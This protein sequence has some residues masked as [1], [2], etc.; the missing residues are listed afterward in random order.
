MSRNA[1]SGFTLI[2]LLVAMS[3]MALGLSVVTTTLM[4]RGSNFE[5]RKIAREIVTLA[6]ET[7]YRANHEGRPGT[8]IFDSTERTLSN[9]A[10]RLLNLPEPFQVEMESAASAGS[11]R[12]A[13]YPGGI[14]SGGQVRLTSSQIEIVVK[15]DWLTSHIDMV[16]VSP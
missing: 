4:R 10:G 14:S 7:R 12:I 2:E 9:E 13:F 8:L 15:V 11:G 16:E 5:A 6:R 3:I 1:E